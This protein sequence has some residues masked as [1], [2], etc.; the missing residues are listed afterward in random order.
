MTSRALRGGACAVHGVVGEGLLSR[1]FGP[2][3]RGMATRAAVRRAS[4]AVPVHMPLG[5]PS[6]STAAVAKSALRQEVLSGQ[7][8]GFTSRGFRCTS[9]SP[10]IR[11]DWTC[12]AVSKDVSVLSDGTALRSLRRSFSWTARCMERKGKDGHE[13]Y[14][15]PALA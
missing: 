14:V 4:M 2:S 9:S 12:S 10:R 15:H 1:G 8:R 13:E 5:Y 11:S 6:Y 3:S 7:V